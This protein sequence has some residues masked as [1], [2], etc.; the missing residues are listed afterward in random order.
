MTIKIRGK[1]KNKLRLEFEEEGHT[2]LNLVKDKAWENDDTDKATYRKEHP[3]LGNPEFL[4][5]TEDGDPVN[6]LRKAAQDIIEDTEE[7]ESQIK[8]AF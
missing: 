6:V 2:L 3:Y 7:F 4:I 8:D 5:E 1:G